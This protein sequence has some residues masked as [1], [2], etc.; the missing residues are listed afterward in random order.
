MVLPLLG[1][2]A[3][4]ILYLAVVHWY[5][6]IPIIVIVVWYFFFYTPK[7]SNKK[8][9]SDQSRRSQSSSY[10]SY[11][12]SDDSSYNSD[13]N[14][15][16]NSRSN[17]N[18]DSRYNS[19][20]NSSSNDYYKKNTQDHSYQKSKSKS[21]RKSRSKSKASQAKLKRVSDRLEKYKITPEE[22]KIIFG[23]TWRAKLGKQEWE[24]YYTVRYIEI[25]VEFDY[26]NRARK[27]FG[28][29][30]SKVLQIIQIVMEENADMREEEGK[31]RNNYSGYSYDDDFKW[32]YDDYDYKNHHGDD[33][34]I[35]DKDIAKAFDTFGLTRESTK[36]QIKT[37]YRKLT[38]KFHPDKNKSKDSTVKMTEI[39]KA[40]EIIM[41][42]IP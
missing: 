12:Q 40:Y 17:S 2:L 42:V 18:Y 11:S 9:E 13:Y 26:N 21:K 22:A 36:E 16:S 20:Y 27:K 38:L 31:Q 39:N 3:F 30:Y 32:N 6:T 24:F 7:D 34:D 29:L 1:I 35:D 19:D 10:Q 33:T 23:R 4:V 14:S 28:E 5:I 25:D 15:R 41:G 37:E 8:E